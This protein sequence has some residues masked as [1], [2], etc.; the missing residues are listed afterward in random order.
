MLIE[1]TFKL[2]VNLYIIGKSMRKLKNLEI[3][4]QQKNDNGEKEDNINTQ[5]DEEE[6]AEA[7]PDFVVVS[8]R[9]FHGVDAVCQFSW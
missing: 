6:E 9:I 1:M 4:L 3:Y 2:V 5:E 8:C 7:V